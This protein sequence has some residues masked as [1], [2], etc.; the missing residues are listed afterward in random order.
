M[1]TCSMTAFVRKEKQAPWGY[2]VWELRSVNHRYL[3]LGFSLPEAFTCLEPALRQQLTQSL[4][5]G[6]ID[7]KLRYKITPNAAA[8]LEIDQNLVASLVE[9]YTK[10]ATAVASSQSLDPVELLRWPHVLKLPEVAYPTF[11]PALLTLFSE[12]L[13]EFCLLRGREGRAIAQVITPRLQRLQSLIDAAQEKLPMLRKMQREKWVN[14]FHEANIR[15]DSERLEQ[16]MLLFSQKI[17]VTEELDRLQIHLREVSKCLQQDTP[18][19]KS[20]DF[21]LQ[22]LNREANTITAKLPDAKLSLLAINMKIL[23]EE[24]REQ[25]QNIE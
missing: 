9:A 22:E 14:R 21:L 5:R 6:K 4:R 1:T 20:L 19:G 18:Q 2:A 8:S 16:E 13:H 7:I 25:V 15:L 11:Q 10:L 12:A 23:I 17:D 24:I 3:E